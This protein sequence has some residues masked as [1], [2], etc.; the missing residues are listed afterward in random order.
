ML[1]TCVPGGF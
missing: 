1:Q